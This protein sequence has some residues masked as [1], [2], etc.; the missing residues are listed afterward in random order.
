MKYYVDEHIKNTERIFPEQNRYGL[1]RFDMNENPEG[2][3]ED[4]VN[5]VLKE[6]TP[7]F[8]SIYPEP[9]R[10]CANMR[11]LSVMVSL[12]TI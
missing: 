8:L 7:E 11:N 6:I 2:L 3:P 12:W 5:S 9:D 4:F 1:K 10:F